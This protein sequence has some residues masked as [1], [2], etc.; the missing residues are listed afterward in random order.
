MQV[1]LQGSGVHFTIKELTNKCFHKLTIVLTQ[2]I[3]VKKKVYM[4]M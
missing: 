4:Y 3:A 2:S 1:Y